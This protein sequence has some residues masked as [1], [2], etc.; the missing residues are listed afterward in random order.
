MTGVPGVTWEWIPDYYKRL[1]TAYQDP[2]E[3]S[4]YGE[5]EEF[6]WPNVDHEGTDRF[7]EVLESDQTIAD[8]IFSPT[9][10]LYT[11]DDGGSPSVHFFGRTTPK[12]ILHVEIPDPIGRI[13]IPLYKWPC[14][15]INEIGDLLGRGPLEAIVFER[16][17]TGHV[18][19]IKDARDNKRIMIDNPEKPNG[20]KIEEDQGRLYFAGTNLPGLFPEFAGEEKLYW[21]SPRLLGYVEN[22]RQ[23]PHTIKEAMSEHPDLWLALPWTVS[24]LELGGLTV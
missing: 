1:F 13:D 23:P 18:P 12:A 7:P 10:V 21:F 5:E 24:I 17:P 15:V 20:P 8:F 16:T 2:R 4:K 6:G 19:R 22:L 3:F 11:G 14:N 9:S